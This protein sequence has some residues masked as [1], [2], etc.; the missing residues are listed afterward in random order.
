MFNIDFNIVPAERAQIVF[1]RFQ[2]ATS[3]KCSVCFY[4]VVNTPSGFDAI[5][6]YAAALAIA[7]KRWFWVPPFPSLIQKRFLLWQPNCLVGGM[8]AK[9]SLK[10]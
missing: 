1:E 3:L 10:K 9:I 6:D 8:I 7:V 2:F 5:R 4:H